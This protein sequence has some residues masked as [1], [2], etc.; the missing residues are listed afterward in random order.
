MTGLEKIIQE[1]LDEADS[2]AAEVL[3]KAKL[4][5][6]AITDEAKKQGE[7]Q[8]RNILQQSEVDAAD[9]LSRAK[10]AAAL[11]KRKRI[12]A[13]KQQIIQEVINRARQQLYSLPQEQYF[14]M[15]LKM[16]VKYV[17]P[18]KGVI[19]FSKTDFERLPEK[20]EAALNDAVKEKGA[21]LQI[22]NETRDIDG[23]F[24]LIYGGVEQ[25]C[26]FQALFEAEQE[27]MLDRVHELLFL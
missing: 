5:A 17:L 4:Q 11:Q 18:Q 1:I 6:Q 9:C 10:S 2:A 15:I 8:S 7:I 3:A 12:L 22:S 13:A 19:A 24:I 26:S 21:A 16:A 25:N 20:F 27:K 23:G 14:A